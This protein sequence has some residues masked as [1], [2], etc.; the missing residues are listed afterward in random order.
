[1]FI[2]NTEDQDDRHTFIAAAFDMW[3]G[4]IPALLEQREQLSILLRAL[5]SHFGAW[6]TKFQGTPG[7]C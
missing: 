3:P 7:C 1:M 2:L 6:V 4:N 5:I